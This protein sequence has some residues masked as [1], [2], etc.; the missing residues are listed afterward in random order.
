MKIADT[1]LVV[2][3]AFS[4]ILCLIISFSL[5]KWPESTAILFLINLFFIPLLSQLGGNLS[6]KACILMAGN[7]TAVILNVLLF[8]F[9]KSLHDFFGL[10]TSALLMII[11]P[12][13]TL[14]WIVPFWSLTLSLLSKTSKGKV[15]S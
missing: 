15:Q 7:F 12:I 5:L 13:L 6:A 2:L 11:Y 8:N 10:P 14:M 4:I 9:A 1:L 3:C